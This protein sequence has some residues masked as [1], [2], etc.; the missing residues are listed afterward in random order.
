MK[1]FS[2]QALLLISSSLLG[3]LDF[4]FIYCDKDDDFFVLCSDYMQLCISV[5]QNFWILLR[6]TLV[7]H[8]CHHFVQKENKGFQFL[9]SN[10][11]SIY[12]HN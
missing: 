2:H 9:N 6:G 11:H 5:I 12:L 10:S 7:F 3:F 4:V 1:V 8:G